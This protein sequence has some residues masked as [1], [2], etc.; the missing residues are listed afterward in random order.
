[1]SKKGLTQ[2]SPDLPNWTLPMHNFVKINTDG[3]FR[4]G[5]NTGGW[6]FIVRNDHG[7]PVAAG[8]GH[9]QGL[10]SALQAEANA[11]LQAIKHTS[12]MGC[13]RVQLE[14][15]STNLKKAITSIE[16]DFSP[17]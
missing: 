7:I 1:M 12:R 4:E 8:C 2:K 17:L 9:N 6:G 3:A 10:G 13:S 11:V 16:Y 5:T 15:D 14:M